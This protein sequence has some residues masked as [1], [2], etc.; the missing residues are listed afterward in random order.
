MVGRLAFF[1]NLQRQKRH[2]VIRSQYVYSLVL[3]SRRVPTEHRTSY[4]FNRIYCTLHTILPLILSTS[5]DV[6]CLPLLLVQHFF[7]IAAMARIKP[8][9]EPRTQHYVTCAIKELVP[10]DVILKALAVNEDAAKQRDDYGVLPLRNALKNGISDQVI[11]SL[12]CAKKL[13]VG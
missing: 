5:R 7:S 2:V 11:I 6:Y 1:F 10:D 13:H 9:A 8:P 12:I 3:R 4:I